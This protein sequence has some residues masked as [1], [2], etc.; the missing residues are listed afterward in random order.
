[1]A[2]RPH[3]TSG[4]EDATSS[5]HLSLSAT[6]SPGSSSVAYL[7][8]Q[9]R[10]LECG[11]PRCG[12]ST[13]HQRTKTPLFGATNRF[14]KFHHTVQGLHSSVIQRAININTHTHRH[15]L[16]QRHTDT[17]TQ[18]HKCV[19]STL[20]R[21]RGRL[22]LSYVEKGIQTPM[23]QGRST[24]LSYMAKWI[25]TSSLGI[26]NSLSPH[27]R[28]RSVLAGFSNC[29]AEMCS[30]SEVGSYLRLIDCCITQL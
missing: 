29:F 2:N 8:I 16:T 9:N 5:K 10:N 7:V 3:P 30:S 18:T 25:R 22:I 26:K 11:E 14:G 15:K 21:A 13:N 20:P 12:F 24:K 23:A 4:R 17:Q 28:N 1:M 19:L 27:T 6:S